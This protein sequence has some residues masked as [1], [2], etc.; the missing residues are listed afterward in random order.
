M[1]VSVG[2]TGVLVGIAAW[3]M[4]IIVMAAD[5]AVASMSAGDM[6]GAAGSACHMPTTIH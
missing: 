5:I 2:G 6:V 1:G 4:A 3:V